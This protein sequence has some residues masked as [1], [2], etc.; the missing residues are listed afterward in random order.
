MPWY[1]PNMKLNVPKITR[2]MVAAGMNMIDLAKK[3]GCTRQTLY[4]AF[5]RET[6]K[7]ATIN[8]LAKALSVDPKDLLI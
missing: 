4:I 7:L 6:T 2:E 8:K 5:Q 1:F 3:C